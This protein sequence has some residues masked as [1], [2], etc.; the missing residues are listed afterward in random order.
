ML[1]VG[2]FQWLVRVMCKWCLEVNCFARHY[3]R[4]GKIAIVVKTSGSRGCADGHRVHIVFSTS[5][6]YWQAEKPVAFSL[7][8]QIV[9]RCLCK[10]EVRDL[11]SG[12]V[13]PE[14][15][16]VVS[17]CRPSAD[18]RLS[19]GCLCRG[20]ACCDEEL[21]LTGNVCFLSVID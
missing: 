8:C 1:M 12:G 11:A 13:A 2:H 9:I 4:L 5:S 6:D 20:P 7:L 21:F 19:G 15:E 16:I 10:S 14:G 3:N 18:L 17:T